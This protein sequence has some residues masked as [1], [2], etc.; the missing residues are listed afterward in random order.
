M[1]TD[2][3]TITLFIATLALVMPWLYDGSMFT[4]ASGKDGLTVQSAS[5]GNTRGQ[6]QDIRNKAAGAFDTM[7]SWSLANIRSG[8]GFQRAGNNERD[9]AI[10]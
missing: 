7:P 1:A 3:N 4:R 6:I 8:L 9:L 10:H 2:P 5:A